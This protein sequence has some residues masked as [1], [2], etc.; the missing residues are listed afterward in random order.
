MKFSLF[1]FLFGICIILFLIVDSVF[2]LSTEIHGL[3]LLIFFVIFIIYMIWVSILVFNL[4]SVS[5]DY[6]F[7]DNFQGSNEMRQKKLFKTV[8]L[9]V[10]VCTLLFGTFIIAAVP[11]L[12]IIIFI[13]NLAALRAAFLFLGPEENPFYVISSSKVR[14]RP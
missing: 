8:I 6:A 7:P 5:V 1:D 13:I 14:E 4:S 9:V 10:G 3:D 2:H 12:L 11:G